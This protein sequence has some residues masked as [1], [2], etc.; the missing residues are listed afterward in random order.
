MVSKNLTKLLGGILV[1]GAVLYP[2]DSKG[3]E[4]SLR[5]YTE[6]QSYTPSDS[7]YLREELGEEVPQNIDSA[8]LMNA[9]WNVESAGNPRAISPRG[10]RGKYQLRAPAVIEWNR[11]HPDEQHGILDLYDPKINEKIAWWYV[12][13]IMNVYLPAYGLKKSIENIAA[14]YNFG[15]EALGMMGDAVENFAKLPLEAR[16]YVHR[17]K[18]WYFSKKDLG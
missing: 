16:N 12:N 1:A 17:I 18:K 8:K 10:A 13:K 11:E 6:T 9:I 4:R 15:T 14:M 2:S 7:V 3:T 5:P